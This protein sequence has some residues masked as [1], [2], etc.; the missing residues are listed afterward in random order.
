[1]RYIMASLRR[2][3]MAQRLRHMRAAQNEKQKHHNIRAGITQR[4]HDARYQ[5]YIIEIST[6]FILYALHIDI[7]TCFVIYAAKTQ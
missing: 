5:H 6:F 3:M 2:E 1:M 7:I 4:H